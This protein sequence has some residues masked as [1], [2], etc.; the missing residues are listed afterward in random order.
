MGISRI[1]GKVFG[2]AG[3]KMTSAGAKFEAKASRYAATAVKDTERV[4]TRP[5]V[6]Q[7]PTLS[8]VI[9]KQ[10]KALPAPTPQQLAAEQPL[11]N[12]AKLTGYGPEQLNM[13]QVITRDGTHMR[14]YRK[15]GSDRVVFETATKG[16]LRTERF[17]GANGDFTYLKSIG[18]QKYLVRKQGDLTFIN[19]RS[20][21]YDRGMKQQVGS[22]MVLDNKYGANLK[23]EKQYGTNGY[24]KNSGEIYFNNC[25]NGEPVKGSFDLNSKFSRIDVGSVRY[26]A[27]NDVLLMRD[28]AEKAGLQLSCN[29]GYKPNVIDNLLS[30]YKA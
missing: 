13:S 23:L 30:S 17:Y 7:G 16:A 24:R 5:A 9:S 11:L 10:P 21:A 1:I 22:D 26:G 3:R 15:P 28:K 6:P 27:T 4:V 25:S 2:Y 8:E 20:M 29:I 19:K 12:T 18:D 14:Y